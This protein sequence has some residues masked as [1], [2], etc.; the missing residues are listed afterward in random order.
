MVQ[1][2]SGP[3]KNDRRPDASTNGTCS[4][5]TRMPT[6]SRLNDVIESMPAGFLLCDA[7]DRIVVS[8]SRFRRWFFPDAESR[9]EAGI[10]YQELLTR[11]VD[12]GISHEGNIDPNW[13]AI[14][15]ERHLNPG[16]PFEHRLRDGRV[17]KTVE[18]RTSDGGIV[19]IHVDIT[20]YDRQ[21]R[22]AAEKSDHLEV[23]LD[24]IGHGIS[25]FDVDLNV[26]VFNRQFL[27]L[28]EFPDELDTPGTP[29]ADFIRYNAERG[30]YGDG[31]IDRLVQERVDL[32]AKFQAHRFDRTRPDGTI[33]EICGTPIEGGGFVTTYT[34]VTE[35]RRAEEALRRRDEE[36]TV[37]NQRFNAALE[38]MSQG[39][40]MFDKDRRLLVCNHRFREVYD[41]P[42]H[43]VQPGT[44]FDDIVR[45]MAERGDFGDEDLD[46]LLN[47]RLTA[48]QDAK[49]VT[50]IRQMTNDRVVAIVSQP[51]Q[52]G[53]WVSTH[54]DITE[55]Q[56]IQARVA[57]MALH[58]E[59][60]DLPNRTLMR[61][62]MEHVV[63]ELRRGRN[64]A[65]LCLDLDRFKNVNDTIGHPMGDKLL[66]Q[67]AERL[68]ACVRETDVV[69]RLGGD[70]FAILQIAENQ[71]EAATALGERI[72]EIMARPFDL[73]NHQV[74][75][76]ASVGIAVAPQ[77]G[78]DPDDLLKNADMALYRAKNDGR[79][80][81][82]F[83]E[84]EMDARM[85]ARRHLEVDLRKALTLN[86]FALHYQPLVDLET[87]EV[88]GFE[89]LLRWNHPKRGG[90]SPADFIPIA[91]EI[92][93]IVGLGEWVV[94]Q[95]CLDAA[96][97][98]SHTKVAVNLSPAQFRSDRLVETVFS[99]LA[100]SG[101][102]PS[103]LELEITEH[104]LLHQSEATLKT[105]HALRDM[106]VR[107]AMDD[108]GTGYSSLSYLRSFPFDKIKIDRSFIKDLNGENDADVIVSAVADLSRNLGMAT[109]AEGVETETQRA[110]VRAAGYTEMQGFLFSHPKPADEITREF[111]SDGK[112]VKAAG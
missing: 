86:E 20:E 111:F 45:F 83:F 49:S 6:E 28:L 74:V 104:A 13:V 110:L 73:E 12:S 105:L 87:E 99:A 37:Q 35:R 64:C 69:A 4:G 43:L 14:R 96:A 27:D 48:T 55:L 9:V 76:G 29:F 80:I 60:T 36:L 88:T 39:L 67:A 112:S 85:Q 53:G 98:P 106:G 8:N 91:E 79:G 95:A 2:N 41:L 30:E 1:E 63:P 70:E 11:F 56:R 93:L 103:R 78:I 33:I 5:G 82:R 92:G 101:L 34:D 25:M 51:M 66:Q 109:T 32:A 17:L 50:K 21:R 47:E 57:H 108:F 52:D 94:R 42:E 44:L 24:S 97:W 26:A 102:A 40:T 10:S 7:D 19:S 3:A 54:E 46:G 62:R 71:P 15:L 58:D 100:K 65:V 38:N 68:R 59:L 77:D 18:K 72:C 81:Y 89:A 16:E 23:V 90:V 61:D 107:I 31:D 75:V 84:P 22:A